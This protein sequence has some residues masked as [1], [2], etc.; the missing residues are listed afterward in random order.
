MLFSSYKAADTKHVLLD[1]DF[2]TKTDM[3]D[4]VICSVKTFD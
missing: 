3:T 2:L 1:K 4:T